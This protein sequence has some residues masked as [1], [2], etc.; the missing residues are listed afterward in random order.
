MI[1]EGRTYRYSSLRLVL[2]II[3]LALLGIAPFLILG[4]INNLFAFTARNRTIQFSGI[5]PSLP[6]V[7]LVVK[8]WHQGRAR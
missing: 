4:D 5:G 3:L 6:I 7:Y 1:I 2:L 8:N